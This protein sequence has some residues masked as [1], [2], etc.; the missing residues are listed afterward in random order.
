MDIDTR[1]KINLEP[2]YTFLTED[3]RPLTFAK[4]LDEF[5]LEH[6]KMLARLQLLD[7]EDNTIHENTCD[8]IHY[9]KL[10]RD[11]LPYCEILTEEREGD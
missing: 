5:L 9:I 8:F 1:R 2:I 4:L 11:I 3:T 10:L 7:D 6:F